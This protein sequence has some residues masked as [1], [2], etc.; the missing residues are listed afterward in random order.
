MGRS[1][2]CLGGK[3]E[4]YLILF[5]GLQ[6]DFPRVMMADL[7]A[8]PRI[9]YGNGENLSIQNQGLLQG[10]MYDWALGAQESSEICGKDEG[11]KTKT[12]NLEAER[13][14]RQRAITLD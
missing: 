7:H 6:R 4:E 9:V 14:I 10:W 8:T 1:K 3:N 12:Y 13:K 11:I 2:N 5:A